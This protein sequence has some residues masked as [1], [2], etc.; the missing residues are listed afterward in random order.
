MI[1][2][3]SAIEELERQVKLLR[4]AWAEAGKPGQPDVPIIRE[5]FVAPTAVVVG[6]VLYHFLDWLGSTQGWPLVPPHAPGA[7]V[8]G[9]V[10]T[11]LPDLDWA[12]VFPAALAKLLELTVGAARTWHHRFSETGAG[13]W[14]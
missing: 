5:A 10:P 7:E 1:G 3:H 8:A 11:L 2:P 6:A 12:G 14:H 4:A 9:G 13:E